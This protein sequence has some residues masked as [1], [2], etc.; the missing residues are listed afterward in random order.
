MERTA[1]CV[2]GGRVGGVRHRTADGATGELRAP[3]TVACDGRG[4]L[5]R[6]LP[7]LGPEHFPCPMDA[8]WFR[9]PRHEDAPSG[10]VGAL[11]DRFFTAL[12]DR[13]DCPG[14][15]GIG[16]AAHAMS[17]VGGIGIN[18]AVQDAVAA[19]RH[20]VRPLREGTVGL[21]D[22]RRVQ[23]RRQPTTVATQGLQRLAHTQVFEP[24]LD[25]RTVFGNPRRAQR[26]TELVTESPW[27]N[28]I[29]AYFIAY[30]ALRERPP[31]ESL[32]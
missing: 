15:L 23:R 31:A 3:L 19:A 9:L 30:G 17:P 7:E 13:G 27:L 2:E 24:L 16:D 8:W 11:G 18:L 26:M 22:V 20:L 29:P 25:G 4:S 21:H 5:A 32:R 12:I 14:L 6:A 10:L 1:C 28:R